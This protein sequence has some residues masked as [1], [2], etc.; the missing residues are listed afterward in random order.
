MLEKKLYLAVDLGGTN[1][2]VGVVTHKGQVIRHL[3]LDT[4]AAKG[5][6]HVLKQIKKGLK[7][8][9]EMAGTDEYEAVGIGAPGSVN[10]EGWVKYPPNFPDWKEVPVK[11]EIEQFV[12]LPT[13][14][15]NDANVVAIGEG[16]F[17]AGKDYTDFLCITLGTGV[18]GGLF[19][20][21]KIYRGCGWAAGEMGHVIIDFK[22]PR[23]NCG[24]YGC[25]ERYV[26]AQYISERAAEKIKKSG[27]ET[28]IIEMTQSD[29]SKITPKIIT[30]AAD[31]GDLLAKEVLK[32]TGELLG[33]ALTSVINL[34]NLPLII[35]TGG[36]SQA[37]AL[38][39][40]PMKDTIY[41]RAL[42]IPREG[43]KV[44]TATLG[45]HAGVI[46]A[47]ALAMTEVA[48]DE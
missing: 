40:K 18:G 34:L 1:V 25:I 10:P 32:E 27:N 26:G 36:V 44:A 20:N 39:L 16:V 24:N 17:G 30:E 22:G 42:P 48:G 21:G 23:C 37:G 7:K 8:I 2:K 47:A 12:N 43:F 46:G 11:S 28:K 6:T 31:Q 14:I 5:P 15:D 3:S 29:F 38:I 41:K 19:L 9:I 45:P 35:V 13:F 4:E 33:V